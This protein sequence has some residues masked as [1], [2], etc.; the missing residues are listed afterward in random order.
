[1]QSYTF[2]RAISCLILSLSLCLCSFLYILALLCIC[3]FMM[4]AALRFNLFIQQRSGKIF[5]CE[6]TSIE[7]FFSLSLSVSSSHLFVA[8]TSF[9]HIII[10]WQSFYSRFSN[11][12][13]VSLRAEFSN[14]YC[15]IYTDIFQ[16][17]HSINSLQVHK[18]HLN[19]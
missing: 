6:I 16:T 17:K 10:I 13:V 11:D 14:C 3:I 15:A 7:F 19:R 8:F 4:K 12:V 2:L 1:M 18:L 5:I 9:H